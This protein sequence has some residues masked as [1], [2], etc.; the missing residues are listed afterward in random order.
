MMTNAVT[1]KITA[2]ATHFAEQVSRAESSGAGVVSLDTVDVK[3]LA[4]WAITQTAGQPAKPAPPA[5]A[6]VPEKEEEEP[7]GPRSKS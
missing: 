4:Q 7:R 3:T 1:D 5:H 6:P 2:I